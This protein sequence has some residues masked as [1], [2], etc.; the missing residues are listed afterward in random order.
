[1]RIH[2]GAIRHERWMGPP[3]RNGWLFVDDRGLT[4]ISRG[5]PSV[6]LLSRDCAAQGNVDLFKIIAVE[7]S[8][9]VILS[10]LGLPASAR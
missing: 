6:A 10:R 1:M 3:K 8:A 4:R 2:Y 7:P 5:K 9:A